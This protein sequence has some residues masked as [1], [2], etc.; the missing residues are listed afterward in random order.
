M[1]ADRN[2][3][4]HV[5]FLRMPDGVASDAEVATFAAKLSL[6]PHEV[7]AV[8]QAAYVKQQSDGLAS[9][10]GGPPEP[11]ILLSPSPDKQKSAAVDEVIRS[12]PAKGEVKA[13]TTGGDGSSDGRITYTEEDGISAEVRVEVVCGEL[14][15]TLIL[16]K[17]YKKTQEMVE[18][19]DGKRVSPPTMEKDAG[20]GSA[21]KWKTSL[22]VMNLDG[23][24]G[25]TC[26]RWID[27]NKYHPKK[28]ES[29]GKATGGD[30]AKDKKGK[31]PVK[32]RGPLGRGPGYEKK[33]KKSDAAKNPEAK[34]K[35][36]GEP[37]A[38]E[39]SKDKP[40]EKK[41]GILEESLDLLLDDDGGL[42]DGK[43]SRLVWLMKNAMKPGERAIV[44]AVIYVTAKH[45]L[46]PF[47]A[48]DGV[49]VL[50][51]WCDTAAAENRVSLVLKILK[52]AK[53]LPMTVEA[54]TETKAGVTV[55]KM[56]KYA[57]E[58]KEN[59]EL[60]LKVQQTAKEVYTKWVNMVN[61]SQ[62]PSTPAAAVP[63][64][65]QMAATPIPKPAAAPQ[66]QGPKVTA[67]PSALK[68]DRDAAAAASSGTLAVATGAP[69]GSDAAAPALKRLKVDV[70]GSKP[71]SESPKP[72]PRSPSTPSA[73]K[74]DDPFGTKRPL[75]AATSTG[76]APAAGG[77]AQTS[78]KIGVSG[79]AA[80]KIGGSTS[81]TRPTTVTTTTTISRP[82]TQVTSFGGINIRGVGFSALQSK[83]PG[84]EPAPK[85]P[86][87]PPVFQKKKS[88]RATKGVT[89]PAEDSQ[90]EAVR[91]IFKDDHLGGEAVA[92][93]D[94]NMP[95]HARDAMDVEGGDDAKGDD[96]DDEEEGLE[97][98]EGIRKAQE[99]QQRELAAEARAANL[100]RQRRLNEM[101]AVGTWRHPPVMT[102]NLP[103][104]IVI[105]KGGDSVEG[106]LM[107]SRVRS[108]PES[109]YASLEQIPDSPAEAPETST[110]HTNSADTPEIP[111][112]TVQ[113]QGQG[114]SQM[115][116]P[117]QYPQRD[118]AV[119]VPGG[120][121]GAGL[122]D[123]QSL[124]AQFSGV[125]NPQGQQPPPR[126]STPPTSTPGQPGQPAAPFGAAPA[127]T[128]GFDGNALQALLKSV[129][130]GQF[131]APVPGPPG[132]T[133]VPAGS[134]AASVTGLAPLPPPPPLSTN[135]G[136]GYPHANGG[137]GAS[138]GADGW[139]Q[140]P[141]LPAGPP[142]GGGWPMQRTDEVPPLP[143]SGKS[144][145][146]GKI[147]SF[148][149]TPRGC[150][151]GDAC[152]FRH[153]RGHPPPKHFPGRK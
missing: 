23:S 108:V 128:V 84:K 148:F 144:A 42:A 50:K 91:Y 94:P 60:T 8:M 117:P 43:V 135:G 61:R 99:R 54:L 36:H 3:V 63:T 16:P 110:S 111:T 95:Q 64:A 131:G 45:R 104:G 71:N 142:P 114:L 41:K 134:A 149:N 122:P 14:K 88:K 44:T 66:T 15:G 82:T 109:V 47:V 11:V 87:P 5:L 153:E 107:A 112:V 103:K 69:A 124:L 146:G 30:G 136:G 57:P 81:I 119:P 106:P 143:P 130:S 89:W 31:S 140:P 1:H 96:K 118:A 4:I 53:R 48:S 139:R 147:C 79:A 132:T 20:K 73:L 22:R 93:P 65:K 34:P 6:K 125:T 127:P 68:R 2:N 17:G 115:Q 86:S 152:R 7:R 62:G 28:S 56:R 120:G 77:A 59:D 150:K 126:T 51:E 76:V 97:E 137:G 49:K 85:P 25:V 10:S 75:H 35:G 80:T 13:D 19:P 29:A 151:N 39:K 105:E 33:K 52:T 40:K 90:L 18:Y 129:Q 83:G 92:F 37:A 72:S 38:T 21:A 123:L 141:P 101:R 145:A 26:Q 67:A 70:T 98:S 74:D 24:V 121:S 138:G 58:G 12:S 102:I 32:E 46:V 78:T 55:K 116:Q 100:T 133:T 113:Q 27:N 9:T